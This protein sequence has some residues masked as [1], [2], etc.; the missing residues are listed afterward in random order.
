[1]YVLVCGWPASGKSTLAPLLAAELGWPLLAKDVLKEALTRALGDP[2]DVPA[3]QQLGRAAVAAM[4]AVARTCRPAVLES[5]WVPDSH[6]DLALLDG[7]FVEV[8]CEVPRALAAERYGL[9][10]RQQPAAHLDSLRDE[11]ELW[12]HPPWHPGVGPVLRVN[13]TRPVDVPA[14]AAAV[15]AA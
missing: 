7:P 8:L 3:S 13:T 9:R 10:S 1:V 2:P 5:S 15:R 12:G 14:L 6:G 4:L 11:D